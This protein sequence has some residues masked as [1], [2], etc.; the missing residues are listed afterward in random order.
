[1][2]TFPMFLTVANRRIIICGGGEQAAQKCRLAL[3]TEAKIMIAAAGE[4]DDELADIIA[5]GRAERHATDVTPDLF[6]DS[7]LVFIATGCKGADAALQ[8]LAKAAGA[9]VN[10]VD[11]P[12]L[13]D[14]LTPSIVDRDPVVVAIGTEGTA[15]V[16]ARQIKTRMEE[17]LE[18]NLGGL[19]ALVGRL[20]DSAAHH[21]GPIQRRDLWRW[22]FS[23]SPRAD[24][25]A[26]RE[27][28]AAKAIKDAIANGG[29]PAQ[30]LP[31]LC[32]VATGAR[33]R[34]M[35]TLRAVKRLQE[36]DVIFYASEF[37]RSYLEF[38]RRDAERVEIPQDQRIE[39][40]ANQMIAEA[41]ADRRVVWLTHENPA[42][43]EVCSTLETAFAAA[44]LKCETVAGVY[45]ATA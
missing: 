11:Q 14:A 9:V 39:R 31:G 7:A 1:M 19:A 32:L 45:P 4:I 43:C 18:P 13:C 12:S 17:L 10:V 28:P 27:R 25:T 37:D 26:G 41:Q 36:A 5:E 20:R 42:T 44:D 23:S 15:P 29:A 40:A 24:F 16:L 6:V 35:M 21:L 22:V 34:D 30:D 8:T 2:K 38:A 3:K 33:G